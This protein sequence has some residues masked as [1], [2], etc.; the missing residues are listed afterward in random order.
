MP[1]KFLSTPSLF[2]PVPEMVVG[3]AAK[4]TPPS[5]CNALPELIVVLPEADPNALAFVFIFKIPAAVV[6]AVP[7][8]IFPV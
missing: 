7:T 2:I 3:S 8:E 1:D 4:A 6:V 5:I